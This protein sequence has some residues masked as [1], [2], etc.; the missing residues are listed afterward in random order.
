[1]PVLEAIWN[2]RSARLSPPWAI[3][4]PIQYIC[5]GT[6]RYRACDQSLVSMVMNDWKVSVIAANQT[7]LGAGE[8]GVMFFKK[9]SKV[10]SITKWEPIS[11]IAWD[12]ETLEWIAK[13][14][15]LNVR[16]TNI[17]RTVSRGRRPHSLDDRDDNTSTWNVHGV[18]TYPKFILV[19]ITFTTDP[20]Q[21]GGFSYNRLDE[22]SFGGRKKINLPLLE[23]WLHDKND[24]KAQLLYAALGDAIVSGQK[25]AGV[26]FFK[27]PGEG[28]M[29]PT[30]KE[31]GFSYQSRYTILGLVTWQEL[32][33]GGLP[34]WAVPTDR[35]DFALDDLPESRFDL[36]KYL[37]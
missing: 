9:Q 25:Y 20:E 10:N 14:E 35:K 28:L 27:K 2:H 4:F 29:T 37:D 7:G 12:D 34:K 36:D 1:M 21:F 8:D 24:E 19:N 17:S 5:A 31:H 30:D 18:M 22:Q 26:R 32:H 16:L 11:Q 6:Y 33:A 15:Q 3:E 23:L 13:S